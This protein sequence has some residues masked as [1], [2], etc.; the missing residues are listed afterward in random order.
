[1]LSYVWPKDRP[2]LRAR[3]AIALGLL[4]GAKVGRENTQTHTTTLIGGWD[5]SF[6]WYSI[7]G[8]DDDDDDDVVNDVYNPPRGGRWFEF[9]IFSMSP[10]K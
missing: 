9:C 3:V 2:D 4:A 6:L 7:D 10:Q 8:D 5:F 1:M